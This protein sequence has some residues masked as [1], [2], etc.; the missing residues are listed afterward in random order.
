MAESA[1]DYERWEFRPATNDH[2]CKVH[3][4]RFD[5]GDVCLDC[6]DDPGEM[7]DSDP[8]DETEHD[9]ELARRE[10]EWR[11]QV[12]FLRRTGRELILANDTGGGAKLIAEATKLDRLATENRE[13]RAQR[14]HE[15]N[16]IQ[17]EREMAGLRGNAN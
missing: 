17:H 8:G 1:H 5:R 11:S 12:K 10:Q 15:R 7:P 13:R 2:Y 14:E 16:T 4:F 3:S 9:R 6:I